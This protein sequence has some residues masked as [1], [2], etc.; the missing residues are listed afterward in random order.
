[1]LILEI[2]LGI[3]MICLS[4]LAIKSDISKGL[5]YNKVLFLFSV[6][7]IIL[8]IL[9]Y[10]IFAQDIVLDF[11][12]NFII[13][14]LIC[15]ILFFTHA[16]AGGDCKFCIILA[17]L[18]PA[19]FYLVYS[20]NIYTL[21]AAIGLAIAFGYIY[22]LCLSIVNLAKGKNALSKQYICSFILAF[23]KSFFSA[24]IFITTINLLI[25]LFENITE[26]YVN[27]WIVRLI[28]IAA[29]WLIGKFDFFRKWYVCA[30]GILFDIVLA[31]LMHAFPLINPGNYLLVTILLLCQLMIRNN[32]YL[33][34]NIADLR[35]GMILSTFSSVLMQNSRVR[36]LPQVSSEDLRNRL[37]ESEV[38]SIQRWAAG[39]NVEKISIVRKIPFAIFLSLGFLCYFIIWSI[40]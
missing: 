11:L 22:M 18:Y 8:D 9:Y 10:G 25:I 3:S 2:A 19:R 12:I 7:G 35:A 24:L 32:L 38:A 21:F 37:T 20:N 5:I 27:I 30:G 16:F 29:A 6:I 33:E 17:L 40:V 13:V 23:A 31:F 15:M 28:C 1:M 39:N 26:I 4:V 34:I 36:G 14:F